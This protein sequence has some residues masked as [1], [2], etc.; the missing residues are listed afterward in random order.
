MKMN[1]SRQD[2]GA[3]V[4]HGMG[5]G[6][7]DQGLRLHVLAS[8]SKGNAAIVED[9]ITGAGVLVDCGICKREFF[10]RCDAVGFDAA[11]LSAVLVTHEHTDHTKGLGVVLRGLAKQGITPTVYA[12]AA[13]RAASSDMRVLE[14]RCDLRAFSAGDALSFGAMVVHAFRTSH[15]AAASFGFRFEGSDDA[16]GFMTDTGIVTGEADEAL[17]DVRILALES[18]HDARMLSEG[19][20]PYPVKR[21]IASDRGHL[22]NDQAASELEALLCTRLEHVVAMHISENNNTYRFPADVLRT[23]VEQAGHHATVQVAYQAMPVSI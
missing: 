4:R 10:A 13:V 18:N 17:H 21:R 20:Y 14:D 23:V 12:D 7:M 15:D 3:P 5:K 1:A 6:R 16:I 8:G 22:S 9:V 11:R 19:A 2:S